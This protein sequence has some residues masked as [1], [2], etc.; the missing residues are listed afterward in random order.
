MVVATELDGGQPLDQQIY[1]AIKEF[2]SSSL[3]RLVTNHPFER[4]RQIIE[5][6][7]MIGAQIDVIGLL[8]ATYIGKY[9]HK[10]ESISEFVQMNIFRLGTRHRKDAL[11]EICKDL[12]I[13]AFFGSIAAEINWELTPLQWLISSIEPLA[14]NT[15]EWMGADNQI[16][17]VRVRP[18]HGGGFIPYEKLVHIVHSRALAFGNPYGVA[19]M[20]RLE[21]L[22]KAWTIAINQMLA[23]GKNKSA[24]RIVAQVPEGDVLLYGPDGKPLKEDGREVKVAGV[25]AMRS[26][27]KKLKSTEDSLVVGPDTNVK[28]LD[29]DTDGEFFVNILTLLHQLMHVSLLFPESMFKSTTDGVG[30]TLSQTQ[31]NLLGLLALS[32]AEVIIANLIASVV[33]PLIVYNFGEQEDGDY[34]AIGI[35]HSDPNRMKL[36]EMLTGLV[37]DG[38]AGFGDDLEAVNALRL[39]FGISNLSELPVTPATSATPDDEG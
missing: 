13:Y 10:N 28:V 32:M 23:C 21:N 31:Q 1:E 16:L 20:R 15:Y 9:S 2:A 38:V 11:R 24:P 8:V 18:N 17:G 27:L 19:L 29:Q 26:E 7:P 30:S 33:A 6:H 34:G 39:E 5:E 22:H 14:P 3:N 36:L 4:W 35:T 25:V 37:G 12:S